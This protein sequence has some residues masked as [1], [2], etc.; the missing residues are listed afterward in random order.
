MKKSIFTRLFVL[1]CVILMQG[2]QSWADT[3]GSTITV[4]APTITPG[5]QTYNGTIVPII[6][7]DEGCSI[8]YV[9][10]T[11]KDYTT[12]ADI[13]KNQGVKTVS[14]N[15]ATITDIVGK[16]GDRHIS[17][18]A[19][20][21]VNGKRY[22]STVTNVT[23]TYASSTKSDITLSAS[24]S[25]TLSMEQPSQTATIS[26]KASD[27]KGTT[28]IT[29]LAYIYEVS[30]AGIVE[31]DNNGI[32]T[33]KKAGTASVNVIFAGNDSYNA[34]SCVIDVNVA[35]NAS[36]SEKVFYSIADIR[37]AA[38]STTDHKN[39]NCA[40]IFKED[41]PATVI[42]VF[43]KSD[44][45]IDGKNT[46]TSKAINS[47]FI[48]DSSNK[49]LWIPANN[50]IVP[51]DKQLS[52]GS[53]FTGTFVGSYKQI[54]SML[55]SF[56]DLK[57]SKE[58]NSTTYTTSI[59]VDNSG[60]ATDDTPAI[61]PYTDIEDVQTLA[62]TNETVKDGDI[63]TSSYGAYLNTI[64]KLPGTIK[65]SV[66]QNSTEYYLVQAENT[67]TASTTNRIYFNSSQIDGINLSDYV[68]T[69][70]VF[71]GILIKRNNSEPKLV[72]LK[73]DFFDIS[74]IYL[75]E[76]DTEER[77]TDLVK[78]GAFDDEVDV[79]IHR[80]K[81]VN[82]TAWNTLC[83]PF[84]MTKDEFK[85]AFGCE[86][87]NLARPA[88]DTEMTLHQWEGKVS[89]DGVLQFT[90][91]TGDNMKITAGVPYL[92][93]ASGTQTVC[94]QT[95]KDAD[96]KTPQEL[97]TTDNT[98]YAHI[99]QKFI[100]VVPPHEIKATYNNSIVKGDFY[101]RGLYGRKK[102]TED[103]EGKLTTTLIADG[104]SQKYQ[105]ISTS[106]GNYLKYLP[107]GSTL[108]FNGMRAYFYFPNWDKEANNKIQ[109]S[110]N[111]TNAKI[112]IMVIDD[113]TTGIK[114]AGQANTSEE[115]VLY[116]LAG[117]KVDRFY[118][119]IVIKNGKKYL[120]K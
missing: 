62:N 119:G 83:F 77:I 87:T 11:T 26:V 75:D 18:Y 9:K 16:I 33:P 38:Q 96:T 57:N 118:R 114:N 4:S 36:S 78:Q 81:L 95:I 30:P 71:E 113:E 65:A 107:S 58:I 25:G 67:Q 73:S 108:Q 55:P 3:D 104:G 28:T 23:Y 43:T 56:T 32:V 110:G 2:A 17:A 100:Y 48:I 60:I 42:A 79:Y 97:M 76:N 8:V 117:Q 49:G 59:T 46:T 116:N 68:G 13:D 53:K 24:L 14:S 52:V 1:L 20:K 80:T 7:A 10:S 34:A 22:C 64:V 101:F 21:T 19:T 111:T 109:P 105:Y 102:Y 91:L 84:D 72:V 50:I 82:T 115:E 92:M 94:T 90:Q 70:G 35:S 86:L 6:T 99:G 98:Y 37:Q 89:T 27:S 120:N 15:S 51:S 88:T 45:D 61:Y 47:F 103:S 31:V 29:G 40:L 12:V 39:E 41:N 69:T 74:K 85:E 106:A 54:T 93:K 112:H 5:S 63:T 66:K 44:P